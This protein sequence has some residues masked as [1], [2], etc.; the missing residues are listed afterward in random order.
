MRRKDTKKHKNEINISF[1]KK[2]SGEMKYNSKYIY[3]NLR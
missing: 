1:N 3:E 2:N